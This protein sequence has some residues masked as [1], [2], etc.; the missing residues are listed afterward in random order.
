M[1]KKTLYIL[2][3]LIFCLCQ[4]EEIEIFSPHTHDQNLVSV[5]SAYALHQKKIENQT[6]TK[7]DFAHNP[8]EKYTG[9]DFEYHE[10]GKRTSIWERIKHLISRWLNRWSSTGGYNLGDLAEYI[11][12]LICGVIVS[13]AIYFSSKFLAK[14]KGNLLFEKKT[15]S[16]NIKA[17]EIIEDI[18]EFDFN[19]IISEYEIQGNFKAALR[20]H[21]LKLLKQYADLGKIHWTQEKTNSDYLHE[22]KNQDD[23]KHF[24]RAVY[25]FDHVWYGD[26]EIGE[27]NYHTLI[28]EVQL[29]PENYEE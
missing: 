3:I 29:K 4:A 16:F 10:N 18:H 1:F 20:F 14:H 8:K 6:L 11:L 25:I 22:L 21:F 19:Q 26:F 23:K 7:R 27:K 24:E 9:S 13:I 2:S 5:D 12:Y 15:K 28:Q 17:D